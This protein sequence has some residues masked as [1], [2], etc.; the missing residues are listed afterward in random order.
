[1]LDR[2]GDVNAKDDYGLTLLHWAAS[3]NPNPEVAALLLARGADVNA[4]NDYGWTP[5]HGAAQDNPDPAVAEL[6]LD[7]GADVHVGMD[8]G[9]TPCD[10]AGYHVISTSPSIYGRLCVGQ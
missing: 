1:M 2:G 10:V 8:N 9:D 3:H 6:L 4:K 5:L 7:R